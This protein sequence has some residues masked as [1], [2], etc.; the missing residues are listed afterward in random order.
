M[1]RRGYLSALISTLSLAVFAVSPAAA[2]IQVDSASPSAAPQGTI[3]LNV[4]ITGN[5]FKKGAVAQWFVT[6]T[7]NPGGVTVNS[8]TFKGST[9][10]T[11]NITVASDAVINGFDIVVRN[12]DGRTGKG[13][14][15]F[16]V[17]QKGTPVGCSTTGTPSGF[18]LVTV[19]NPVQSDGA[20]SIKS[21]YFGNAIRVRPIDLNRDGV[22]D[23][24]LAFVTSGSGSGGTQG[25][26]VFFLNPATGQIQPSDPVTGVAWQNPLLL[27][28]GVRAT[29]AA[30]GD[31][32]GDGIP[33]FAMAIPADAR[34]YL[35]VGSVSAS[36]L[37]PSYTVYPIQPP[38][39]APTGW[40]QSV[41][42]GDLDG[43]GNDEVL[44]GAFP[45]K[46]EP[47]IP[48]VFI[49]KYA[50]GSLNY[51]QKIQ[52]P[53]GT[54]EGFGG[55]IAV[56]NIDGAAGNELV[57]GAPG[58][59]TTNGGSVYVFPSPL[60]QSSFFSL[61]GPGPMFG[62][63][64]GI[65]DVNLD[66]S[67]DLAVITG[68]QFN[69][70]DLTARA[71]LYTGAVHPGATF[72]NQLLPSSGNAYSFGAPNTDIGDMLAAGA[73]LVGAPNS[74]NGSNC[75]RPPGSAQLF[76]SPFSSTTGPN[77]LFEPPSLIGAY[78]NYGYGVAVAPGYPFILVGEKLRDVGTTLAAGQVYVYMKN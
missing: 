28:T 62:R 39:G 68:D 12:A 9:Q 22:V 32:N 16:A 42:M 14:D 47:S 55:A 49:F 33:D 34:A 52:D 31:V 77:Y 5:G 19:L 64:L 23:S 54:G 2:Q 76:T 17:T 69:G 45:G 65:A 75:S 1:K 71:L 7:T 38:P 15:R 53:P 40:A 10:V 20:A 37:N 58:A 74:N 61:T 3:N 21:V 72:T 36:T 25:T 29:A 56:G 41:A 63:G 6:G 44:V 18:S 67:P 24:L 26:Y 60:Q 11:A 30:A 50:A 35:F 13:T 8:T 59:S 66:G 4:V 73:L 57:V 46:R 48:A 27:L 78:G 70:S 51:A 43:D